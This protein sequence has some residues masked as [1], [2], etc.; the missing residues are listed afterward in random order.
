MRSQFVPHI[1]LSGGSPIHTCDSTCTR[2]VLHCLQGTGLQVKLLGLNFLPV[3]LPDVPESPCP[4]P[5]IQGDSPKGEF[6]QGFLSVISNKLRPSGFPFS[7]FKQHAHFR[8][9]PP[10]F[11]LSHFKPWFEM[12]TL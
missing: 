10:G 8:E 12:E 7:H 4:I 3:R 6:L 11:P 9:I 5:A 2:R 1:H